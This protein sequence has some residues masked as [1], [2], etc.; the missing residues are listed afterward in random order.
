MSKKDEKR[1]KTSKLATLT[2]GAFFGE[3]ALFSSTI[4]TATV[5]AAT[6]TTT[7]SLNAESLNRFLQHVPQLLEPIQ[8]LVKQRTSRSMKNLS[9]F[10]NLT[11]ENDD[12][13]DLLGDLF[14]FT[15]Y[16]EGDVIFSEGDASDDGLYVIVHGSTEVRSIKSNGESILLTVLDEGQPFGELSLLNDTKRTATIIAGDD[17]V[18]LNLPKS[19]WR[20]F[21]STVP[22]SSS[23]FSSIA[24]SRTANQL[25]TMPLFDAIQIQFDK[26]LKEIA[27]YFTYQTT[28]DKESIIVEGEVP[29]D[30]YILVSGKVEVSQKDVHIRYLVAGDSFGE[31]A[32]FKQNG[33]RTSTVKTVMKCTLLKL[34]KE[35]WKTVLSIVP[36]FVGHFQKI[37]AKYEEMDRRRM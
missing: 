31:Y 27:Q 6:E 4:R 33:R 11:E 17:C 16:S 19:S 29:D 35:D 10:E 26:K 28:D 37:V 15:Q 21:L 5:T 20:S 24:Q 22:E 18:L 7:L 25:K 30:F 14:H 32:L 12:A 36:E 1:S 2:Q 13:L 9:F 3:I 23:W 8:D 34:P